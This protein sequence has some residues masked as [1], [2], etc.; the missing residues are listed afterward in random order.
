MQ[1]LPQSYE[2]SK[3]DFNLDFELYYF[4]CTKDGFCKNKFET[5]GYPD[6]RYYPV[7]IDPKNKYL[8]LKNLPKYTVA[9]IV[10]F[11]KSRL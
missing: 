9:D 6:L 10:I 7:A 1:I 4:N 2:Q 5:S 11:I 3:K 8:K